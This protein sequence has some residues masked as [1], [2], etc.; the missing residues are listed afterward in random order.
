MDLLR[1]GE[2]VQPDLFDQYD[3]WN[4]LL[5]GGELDF[6]EWGAYKDGGW[7]DGR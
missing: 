2:I 1:E 3:R 6:Q 4:S 5:D 7:T